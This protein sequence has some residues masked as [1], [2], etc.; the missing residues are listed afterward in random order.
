MG[1]PQ[2]TRRSE[3]PVSNGNATGNETSWHGFFSIF[4]T[5]GTTTITSGAQR[6]A[7]AADVVGYPA[8]TYASLTTGLGDY[9]G[10]AGDSVWPL[11]VCDP[12]FDFFT[13]LVVNPL[14]TNAAAFP[15]GMWIFSLAMLI[16]WKRFSHMKVW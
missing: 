11:G 5:N 15:S 14:S 3:P 8:D 10:E 2:D 4:N 7:N 6:S 1:P 12:E 16:C 13:P 9:G